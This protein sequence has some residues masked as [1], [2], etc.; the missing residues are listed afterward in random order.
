MRTRVTGAS[1]GM[2]KFRAYLPSASDRARQTKTPAKSRSALTE[3]A[4]LFLRAEH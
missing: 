2:E 4:P 3:R 1:H